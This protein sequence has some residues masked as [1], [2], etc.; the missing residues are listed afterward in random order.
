MAKH[1][2][3]KMESAGQVASITKDVSVDA[4]IKVIFY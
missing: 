4:L 3:K 1:F 2:N